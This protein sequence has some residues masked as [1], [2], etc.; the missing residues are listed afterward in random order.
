M[1]IEVYAYL[2]RKVANL[3]QRV[4]QRLK[5]H[6]VEIEFQPGVDL[7][8]T[9]D[10]ESLAILIKELPRDLRR[11]E[12]EA[13]ILIDFGYYANRRSAESEEWKPKGV[14]SYEYSVYTRTS[15]GRSILAG[16]MQYL[17]TSAIAY[18][19]EGKVWVNGEDVASIGKNSFDKALAELLGLKCEVDI[20][21]MTFA[22][23][24]EGDQ[25]ISWPTDVIKAH[26]VP[27]VDIPKK[28]AWWKF[29][30]T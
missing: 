25:R 5:N 23:W 22:G 19:S 8:K 30:V 16:S 18:E 1:S 17:I 14:K 7:L 4:T 3:E 28:T 21:S 13:L 10:G 15:S 9:P 27:E 12:P 29:W 2:G 26:S 6:G 24:P 20:G 11:K